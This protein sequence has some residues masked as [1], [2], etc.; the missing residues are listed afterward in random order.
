LKK[1]RPQQVGNVVNVLTETIE[2]QQD[3]AS[4]QENQDHAYRLQQELIEKENQD[5]AYR[6]Q[7]EMI[8]Y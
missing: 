6:L 7:Q 4:W 2:N 8:K 3:Q 1:P 5:H